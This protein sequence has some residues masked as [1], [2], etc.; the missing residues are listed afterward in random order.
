MEVRRNLFFD[1]SK[2]TLR[3]SENSPEVKEC[4][5]QVCNCTKAV[6]ERPEGE[7]N[8]K[9]QYVTFKD[10]DEYYNFEVILDGEGCKFT[11][12]WDGVTW[13]E[14][15]KWK[16]NNHAYYWFNNNGMIQIEITKKGYGNTGCFFG[17]MYLG[18]KIDISRLFN[19]H[20]KSKI[21]KLEEIAPDEIWM[22]DCMFGGE[23]MISLPS[24]DES[25]MWRQ[26]YEV[27]KRISEAA[28]TYSDDFVSDVEKIREWAEGDDL[29]LMDVKYLC[30]WFSWVTHNLAETEMFRCGDYCYKNSRENIFEKK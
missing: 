20:S 26:V 12:R 16:S 10:K 22:H 15:H 25:R 18:N 7:P 8:Q 28:R 29:M 24:C 4:E 17:H 6:T 5:H 9:Q 13:D 23:V 30:K 11:L 19:G 1:T 3:F 21:V 14:D 27:Q 2:G